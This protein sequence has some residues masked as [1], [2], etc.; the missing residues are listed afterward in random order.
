M[1]ETVS[2][3]MDLEQQLEKLNE[4]TNCAK[5]SLR[6]EQRNFISDTENVSRQTGFWLIE[7]EEVLFFVFNPT[8]KIVLIAKAYKSH[9]WIS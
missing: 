8:R 7:M 5:N 9:L 4:Q 1:I 2:Q 6:I 3:V